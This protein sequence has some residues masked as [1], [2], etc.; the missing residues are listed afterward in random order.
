MSSGP[1]QWPAS[2]TPPW[3]AQVE[4]EMQVPLSPELTMHVV[5]GSAQHYSTVSL[6][7]SSPNRIKKEISSSVNRARIK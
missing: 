3:L 4:V 2:D 7:N 5:G 6:V 1:G